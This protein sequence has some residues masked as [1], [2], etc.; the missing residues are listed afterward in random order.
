MFNIKDITKLFGEIIRFK[1][2]FTSFSY[3]VKTTTHFSIKSMLLIFVAIFAL[4]ITTQA[5]T[6]SPI[7]YYTHD[8]GKIDYLVTAGTFRDQDNSGDV[9]TA[10]SLRSTAPGDLTIPS[11]SSVVSAYLYWGGSGTTADPTVTFDGVTVNATRNFLDQGL[12]EQFFGHFADVTSLVNSQS[13]GTT[14]TY[15]MEDLTVDN[16][17]AYLAVGNTEAVWSLVV[18]YSNASITD[19]HAIYIYDGYEMLWNSS[20]AGNP[21]PS[22]NRTF[23]ISG[24]TV[25]TT[26]NADITAVIFEGDS[27][28]TGNEEIQVNGNVV[29]TG[30]THASSSNVPGVGGAFSPYGLDVDKFDASA[31]VNA[32]DNSINFRVSTNGDKIHVSAVVVKVN[33]Q[34]VITPQL[35][36]NKTAS[37]AGIVS[38]GQTITYT[39]DIE[40]TGT[41]NAEEVSLTDLLPSGVTYTPG[42]AQKTYWAGSGSYTHTFSPLNQQYVHTTGLTQS[43]NITTAEIPTG[44]T[45]DSYTYNLT[46]STTDWLSEITVNAAYPGGTAF[47]LG[48]NSFGGDG[49][50]TNVNR[51]GSGTVSGTA[52][53]TYNFYW[54]DTFTTNSIPNTVNSAS[55]TINYSS[56]R[57]Q[58]TN[59]ASAPGNMVTAGDTITLEPGETMTVTFDATVDVGASGT[60]INT[61]TANAIGIATTVSDTAS[62]TIVASEC[63]AAAS[64][65]LDTDGDGI[66]DI[67]DLDDDNDGI[68]DSVECNGTTTTENLGGSLA[69]TGTTFDRK[70]GVVNSLIFPNSPGTQNGTY[71]YTDVRETFVDA[72]SIRTTFFR[73]GQGTGGSGGTSLGIV[74]IDADKVRQTTLTNSI[75]ASN[76]VEFIDFDADIFT[77]TLQTWSTSGLYTAPADI[78]LVVSSGAITLSVV[79]DLGGG[80]FQYTVTGATNNNGRLSLTSV[81][82]E[83]IKRIK[84]TATD[85]PNYSGDRVQFEFKNNIVTCIDT[86]GDGIANYLDLDSDNDGIPDNIE[87]QSTTGYVAPTGIDSDN[88]GLDD[89]Y[90]TTPNGNSNGAGSLGLTPE[91]TDNT[92]NPDYLDLDSD[93]DGLFDLAE[94]GSGL[95]DTTGGPGGIP[96]GIAD[97]APAVFG[98]NG[99]INSLD[100]GDNYTDVNGTFDD[101]QTDNFTDADGDVNLSGGDVDYRDIPGV[102]TDGDLIADVDDLDDDNDGVLDTVECPTTTVITDFEDNF[103]SILADNGTDSDLDGYGTAGYNAKGLSTSSKSTASVIYLSGPRGT[104]DTHN[105]GTI[106]DNLYG[107]QTDVP[108]DTGDAF[109]YH[110][111]KASFGD[112]YNEIAW[113]NKTA[114]TVI[115]NTVYTFKYSAF[116]YGTAPPNLSVILDE[117]AQD[118]ADNWTVQGVTYTPAT[119]NTWSEQTITFTTGA[120]TTLIYINLYFFAT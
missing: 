86:D 9:N 35:S 99:L 79:T 97:G 81:S 13:A 43:V 111:T 78:N 4:S 84:F 108:G 17:G 102:D 52:L 64:G 2:N 42:T 36:I 7:S 34:G 71:T 62:N 28:I 93:N 25:G 74:D 112:I 98:T 72:T 33:T 31:Y 96:D 110:N 63:D 15:I 89:A 73:N 106:T 104:P 109:L 115:P 14:K 21:V 92:D 47:T 91:N 3:K 118:G 41:V 105:N 6:V 119:P 83:L 120:T 51:T 95:T 18:I 49:A 88:D 54:D 100:N 37:P 46:A 80:V 59:A 107:V 68:L 103:G 5:Q 11:G 75:V 65:N 57:A 58:I 39:I 82:G 40:N 94:S 44:S 60:L 19:T 117:D 69:T 8:S 90:D 87:A 61:A 53:G 48:A 16:T 55:F 66:S 114:I 116:N 26:S 70:S 77:F 76:S 67:C 38:Q 10:A 29:S 30:N 23:T 20:G 12:S 22:S 45:L 32:G 56:P 113:Y 50:G 101:T 85:I 1:R 24:I 27:N